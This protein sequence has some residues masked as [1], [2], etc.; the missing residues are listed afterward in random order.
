MM[1]L[2]IELCFWHQAKTK[3]NAE[4]EYGGP[5]RNRDVSLTSGNATRRGSMV[6]DGL[7]NRDRPVGTR[8]IIILHDWRCGSLAANQLLLRRG[9][10]AD[11]AHRL[12]KM[13]REL[14]SGGRG[15]RG[16]RVSTHDDSA[17]CVLHRPG[18]KD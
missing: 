12:P 3:L 8:E 1:W 15:G 14:R 7:D 4:F 10:V 11:A 5:N 17:Q 16:G 9:S 2:L 6:N 18:L 13:Y